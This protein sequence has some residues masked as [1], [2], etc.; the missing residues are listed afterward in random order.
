MLTK[1]LHKNENLDQKFLADRFF[2][3]LKTNKL[4]D[5]KDSSFFLGEK[6]G[7]NFNKISS[8]RFIKK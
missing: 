8:F 6:M 1:N 3:R 4:P 5:D 7:Q 2:I